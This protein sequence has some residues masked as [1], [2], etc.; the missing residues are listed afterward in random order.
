[1]EPFDVVLL[2]VQMPVLDGVE[3]ARLIRQGEMR[4]VPR[5]LPLVALTA[6]ALKGVRERFL[7]AGMDDYVSK[8]LDLSEIARVLA[9]VA[10]QRER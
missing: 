7:A 5:D 9:R 4:D 8:P 2:D 10:A 6:H 1:P 3:T